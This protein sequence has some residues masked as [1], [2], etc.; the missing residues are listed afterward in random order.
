MARQGLEKTGE[1]RNKGRLVFGG[2]VKRSLCGLCPVHCGILV[3]VEDGRPVR[4]HGDPDN[5]VNAGRLCLKGSA[6]IEVYEHPD[7]LNH[8]LKRVGPRGGGEWIPAA[9]SRRTLRICIWH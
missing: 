5:P 1:N 9:Q 8:V 7:R 2:T 6:V 3:D 4:F